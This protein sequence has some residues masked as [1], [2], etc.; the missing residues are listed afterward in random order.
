[1]NVIVLSGRLTKDPEV[2]YSQSGTA[3]GNYSIA[4]NRRFKK[5]GGQDADFFNCTVFGKS[6][7]FAERYF[8]KGMMVVVSG[9]MES[10]SYA[11]K[12]GTKRTG[13]NVIVEEQ[14]FGEGK[15]D[16]G[17][18]TKEKKA[19]DGFMDIPDTDMTELPFN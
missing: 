10:S 19:D 4:V 1:M 7:E 14:N 3:V 5:D 17:G 9:R 11:G 16:S 8:Q 6:A 18:S 2:R 13:W 15:K 12:D